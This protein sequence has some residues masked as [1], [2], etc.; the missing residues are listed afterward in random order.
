MSDLD[1]AF[2]AAQSLEPDEQLQLVVRLWKALPQDHRDALVTLQFGD[3]HSNREQP[4]IFP[5]V[6][7]KKTIWPKLS[8]VL[9]DTSHSSD[10]YSAPRRFDLATIFVVTAA[11]SLLLGVLS[12]F[13]APPTVMV[14]LAGLLAIIAATQAMF[15]KVANPRG[16]SVVTGAVAYTVMSWIIWVTVRQAFPNSFIVVT[17]IN[18]IIGGAILGYL[19][20]TL[21]GGVFLVA[22]MLRGRFEGRAPGASEDGGENSTPSESPFADDAN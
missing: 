18:G 16:V 3:A 4:D 8:A 12:A 14:V 7:R 9:F 1:D 11:Y 15:A 20:G 19:L 13:G 10:L 21:V 2:R 22:D 17:F 6:Q 5:T